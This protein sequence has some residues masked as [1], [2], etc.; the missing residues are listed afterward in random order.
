MDTKEDRVV[1]LVLPTT[2]SLYHQLSLYRQLSATM[3]DATRVL[4]SGALTILAA[5]M[6]GPL[7]PSKRLLERLLGGKGTHLNIWLLA[8]KTGRPKA[9]NFQVIAN[10]RSVLHRNRKSLYN[11][12]LHCEKNWKLLVTRSNH[13]RRRRVYIKL[14]ESSV[15]L[16][17][18]RT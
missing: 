5:H 15:E 12:R 2:L 4:K 3:E 6:L 1:H 8:T 10:P 18:K 17:V 16:V 9:G 14:V 13:H 11:R 7:H